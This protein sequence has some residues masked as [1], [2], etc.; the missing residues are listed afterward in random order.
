MPAQRRTRL[1]ASFNQ[2]YKARC[3]TL[4]GPGAISEPVP[5]LQLSPLI[6]G[7]SPGEPHPEREDRDIKTTAVGKN[8][9][10]AYPTT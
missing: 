2:G 3:W 10:Y 4:F 5:K 6:T 7:V 1:T 8:S 9:E